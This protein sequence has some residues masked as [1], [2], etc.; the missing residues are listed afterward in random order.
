MQQLS[1]RIKGSS[2]EGTN[3]PSD[4]PHVD[5][6]RREVSQIGESF[7]AVVV[8]RQL[9]VKIPP[10]SSRRHNSQRRRG[11]VDRP[12]SSGWLMLFTDTKNKRNYQV[13]PAAAEV[14]F[15]VVVVFFYLFISY[16]FFLPWKLQLAPLQSEA[17]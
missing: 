8:R 1:L 5:E 12:S 14:C 15:T 3:K 11:N 10:V 17:R 13:V 16:F 2:C 4:L 6:R 9:S 7:A